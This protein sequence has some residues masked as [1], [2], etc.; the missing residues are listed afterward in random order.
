[1]RTYYLII[2]YYKIANLSSN[3]ILLKEGNQDNYYIL[4]TIFAK[5]LIKPYN[6]I[7]LITKLVN[8]VRYNSKNYISI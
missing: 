7:A 3:L 2:Y 8:I 5:D 6:S 1:M 4:I